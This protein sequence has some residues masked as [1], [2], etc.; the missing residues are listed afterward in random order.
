M[1]ETTIGWVKCLNCGHSYYSEKYGN[2][3]N[4][5]PI[6]GSGEFESDK[7]SSNFNI[8]IEEE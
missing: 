6:C 7:E 1:I 4:I 3:A 2:R 5:C 8:D